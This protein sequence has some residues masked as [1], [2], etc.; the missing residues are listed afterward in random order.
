MRG[1]RLRIRYVAC[2]YY[3]IDCEPAN[4]GIPESCGSAGFRV[5][6]QV[7]S[8]ECGLSACAIHITVVE[9]VLVYKET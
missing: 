2:N 7:V 9:R 5:C 8:G 6:R 3:L 4:S 1:L